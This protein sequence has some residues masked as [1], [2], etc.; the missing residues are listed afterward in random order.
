LLPLKLESSVRLADPA[1]LFFSN[2]CYLRSL[3]LIKE[4]EFSF[5]KWKIVLILGKQPIGDYID[6]CVNT[7]PDSPYKYILQLVRETIFQKVKRFLQKVR[8]GVK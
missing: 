2:V 3:G 6:D 8:K 1:L 7:N 5:F 4:K